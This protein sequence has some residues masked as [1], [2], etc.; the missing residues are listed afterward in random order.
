MKHLS[1]DHL[2]QAMKIKGIQDWT[3]LHCAARYD[4]ADIVRILMNPLTH[5]QRLELLEMTNRL[6]VTPRDEAIRWR[7]TET[8]ELMRGLKTTALIEIT[9]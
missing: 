9:K 4:R 5:R 8:A 3:A 7:N 1:G 2:Y 6:S